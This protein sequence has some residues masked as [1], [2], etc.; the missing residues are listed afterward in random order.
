MVEPVC[1]S[2]MTMRQIRE[3]LSRGGFID[4]TVLSQM[5]T[6]DRLGVRELGRRAD[7]NRC[8]RAEKEQRLQEMMAVERRLRENG[9]R[10]VVGLDEAGRGPLA[11][12][13]VAAAVM[14]PWPCFWMGL[15]DSKT[16]RP[17]VREE[18]YRLI[19]SQAVAVGVGLV[20]ARRI[21]RIGIQ[22]ANWEAMRSAAA[23]LS[24]KPDHVVVDGPWKIPQLDVPQT[25]L[26]KGDA[27]AISV[28]AASVVAKV[29]RDRMMLNLDS[30]FPR[31]GFRKHKG[32][33]TPEHLAA[34]GTYGPCR[35]HRRSFHPVS[36]LM[37]RQK[38]SIAM[39]PSVSS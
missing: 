29:T 23:N 15:N 21:D 2:R 28:A 30:E 7:R 13:L 5:R 39:E 19:M 36:A 33:G 8:Q 18:W 16:L 9:C 10:T 14:A 24:I 11:G 27:R 37:N 12:P 17:Q 22:Q 20:S 1:I 31:Y 26:V 38:G 4:E 25:P 6:D 3:F 32:Y 34:I 35:I